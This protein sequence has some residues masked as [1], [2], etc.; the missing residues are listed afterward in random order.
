MLPARFL[1]RHTLVYVASFALI[2]SIAFLWRHG[3]SATGLESALLGMLLG[4]LLLILDLTRAPAPPTELHDMQRQ[5][6]LRILG[7]AC[8]ILG[9]ALAGQLAGWLRKRT[10]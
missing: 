7:T 10:H 9:T 2:V 8:V 1:T 3:L 6:L 5:D 4:D